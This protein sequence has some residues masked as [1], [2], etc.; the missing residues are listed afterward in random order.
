M[1]KS[2][3]DWI[4]S[5]AEMNTL[6]A[7]FEHIISNYHLKTEA[8]WQDSS[9]TDE[10]AAL[11]RINRI[12]EELVFLDGYIMTNNIVNKKFKEWGVIFLFRELSMILCYDFF[13]SG[14]LVSHK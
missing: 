9:I 4:D 13:E 14:P 8:R 3:L 6:M 5:L 1:I 7:R 2:I 11:T 10:A 12:Q